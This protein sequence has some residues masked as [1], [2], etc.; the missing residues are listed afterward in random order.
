ME[1]PEG[2]SVS[3]RKSFREVAHRYRNEAGQTYLLV[4]IALQSYY[5]FAKNVERQSND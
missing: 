2:L 4:A 5:L 1:V 3:D